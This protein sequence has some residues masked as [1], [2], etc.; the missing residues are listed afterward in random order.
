MKTQYAH[1]TS[2]DLQKIEKAKDLK[3]VKNPADI[4]GAQKR[5]ATQ[6]KADEA[7]RT[8]LKRLVAYHDPEV[9]Q[10]AAAG[11]I[12]ELDFKLQLQATYSNPK[13]M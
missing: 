2:A 4:F 10:V 8:A 6:R 3:K 9:D 5:T 13:I 11:R 1:T 7:E 12:R